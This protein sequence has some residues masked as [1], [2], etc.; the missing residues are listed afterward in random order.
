MQITLEIKDTVLDKF[1]WMLEHFKNDVTIVEKES[2]N[3]DIHG[4]LEIKENIAKGD[5]SEFKAID[6]VDEHIKE[7]LD[8]TR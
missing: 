3:I 5:L 1:L 2:E 8:A 6:D 7:L 4:C